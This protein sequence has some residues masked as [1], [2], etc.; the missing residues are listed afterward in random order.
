MWS[1]SQNESLK[2]TSKLANK[3]AI[4]RAKNQVGE[5]VNYIANKLAIERANCKAN[6]LDAAGAFFFKKMR[7]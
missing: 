2:Q 3:R 1:S 7:K 4:W 6:E 5:Q